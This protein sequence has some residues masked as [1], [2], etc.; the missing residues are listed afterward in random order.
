M[1]M[2]VLLKGEEITELLSLVS[3]HQRLWCPR[4]ALTWP[5]TPSLFTGS[6]SNLDSGSLAQQAR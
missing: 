6:V 2:L 4:C 1:G 5:S 3:I